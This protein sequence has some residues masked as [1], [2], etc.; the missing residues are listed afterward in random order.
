[1]RTLTTRLVLVAVALV[2]IVTLAVSGATV[3]AM[4]SYLTDQLDDRVDA[5]A[6]SL[7]GPGD[8][9]GSGPGQSSQGGPTG[10][11]GGFGNQEPDTL[12]V[13]TGLGRGFVSG[14]GFEDNTELTTDQVSSVTSVRGSSAQT[15]SIP[16]IGS[17]RVRAATMRFRDPGSRTTTEQTVVVGLPTEDLDDTVLRLITLAGLLAAGGIALA[18]AAGLLVVRRQLAPL[19][20]V[21][22]TA[23]R[24][25]EVPLSE[26]EA[27]IEERV[28]A[29]LTDERTEVGQ[30]GAALNSL[31]DHVET[32]LEVRHQ[33]EQ[34]VR[35]FVA[36]ASHELRTPLATI[37]GYAE[38]ARRRPDDPESARTA[39]DRVESASERMSSLVEDLLLLARL[40]AGRPLERTPVDLSMLLVEAVSDARVVSPE[41]RWQLDLPEDA[42][43]VVGDEQRLHQIVTNLLTNARR[44]TPAGTVITA[45]ARPG[46]LEIHDDGPGFPAELAGRAFERFV[47]GD[48]SRTRENGTVEG[49]GLGLALVQ[50]IAKAH[51]GRV[52]LDSRPGDTTVRVTFPSA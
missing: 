34:Q 5:I 27:R 13:F 45:R 22:A 50:A 36:D 7:D 10:P 52:T 21:A 18:G 42:V 39:L 14:T 44:Y 25:S 48:Q 37:K 32:S 31:L 29:R 9:P 38:L 30:V 8:S 28:P 20:E 41:H 51:G 40:D 47:R 46:L 19:R 6:R 4:R 11:G 17:Y 15:V 1:M 33:S 49:S 26:G 43:V 24:V 3:L 16:G 12:V 23:H 2:A 35:Q